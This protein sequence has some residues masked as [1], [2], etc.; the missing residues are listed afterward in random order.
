ME[1]KGLCGINNLG[2]TCYLNSIL[3]CLFHCK[4]LIIC[5]LDIKDNLIEG[6]L[7]EFYVLMNEIWFE[8]KHII[9]PMQF[10]NELKEKLHFYRN[11]SQKDSHECM[12]S[13][14]DLFETELT[15]SYTHL[16]LPT[17]LLV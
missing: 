1:D 14:L 8:D 16:T 6:A 17:I 9:Y 4:K 2:N 15:V 3:Q 7:Y 5:I 11:S 12:L 13:L 10:L